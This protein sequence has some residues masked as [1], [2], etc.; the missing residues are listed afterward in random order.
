MMKIAIQGETGSFHEVAARQYFKYDEIEIVPCSTFD[1]ELTLLGDGEVD[2]AVMAI[3]NARSGSI[4]YNYTLIRESGMKILGEHNL[5]IKQNLMAL[6]KQKITDIKEIRTHPIAIAQC[7]TFLNQYPHITLIESDDTAGSAKQ[8]GESKTMGVA[9]IAS[10]HAAE[11]YGLE[12]LAPGIETYKQNY[13]RFLV[14]GEEYKGN[15]RGNKVSICFSTGHKPGSLA[16]VL[17]K[18]AELDINL[19]KIQSVPR[20]NGEWEYMFY[21]DLEVNKNTK[22]DIIQ[23]V[24]EHYTSNLEILG[25]YYKGDMLYDS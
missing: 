5:R 6:P 12:I 9:A 1:L 8:I 4:L 23:R 11:I 13:T 20:L 10:S 17:V 15:T 3:E 16:K 25:V 21:L 14:I 24:L 7:M 22:S 2:F 19:S 18:L